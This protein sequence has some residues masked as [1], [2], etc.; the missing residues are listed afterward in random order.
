MQI[1]LNIAPKTIGT[2][3]Y[4]NSAKSKHVDKLY[5]VEIDM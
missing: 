1:K 3:L 4:K 5:I 2:F